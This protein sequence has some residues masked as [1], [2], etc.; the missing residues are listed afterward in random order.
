M[1]KVGVGAKASA[2]DRALVVLDVGVV[3]INAS[4][5]WFNLADACSAFLQEQK[6]DAIMAE[7]E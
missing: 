6:F 7:L 4:S 2:S 3:S 5:G 1:Y